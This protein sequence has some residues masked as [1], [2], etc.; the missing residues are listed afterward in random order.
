[1][2]YKNIT[3]ILFF[4]LFSALNAIAAN[5]NWMSE[6]P[7]DRILNQLIIP[8]SHDSG[9]YGIQPQS[10]FSLSP[11]DPLPIWIEAISNILPASLLTPIVAGW[12]KTQ[13]YSITEQLNNGIRY[14]DFRVCYFQSHFYLCH[15]LISVRLKN[16][17]QQIQTF[18]QKNPSE[19]IL[20][21]INHVYNVTNS[22]EETQLVQLL[23]N[24]LENTAIPNSYKITDTMKTL[25]KSHHNVIIFMNTS[26]VITDPTAQQFAAKK[27]WSESKIDSPWPDAADMNDLKNTLDTE[28][29]FRD[30]I[31]ASANNLFVLQII[32]TE[33]TDE[34]IDGILN[35]SQYPNAIEPYELPVN[36]ALGDWMNN[37]IAEYGPPPLN[38]IIQDW[39]TT[40]SP[41]VPLAIQYDTVSIPLKNKLSSGAREKLRELK[42]WCL[43][44]TAFQ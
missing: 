18:I 4:S 3:L 15:A 38:I 34:V 27:L 36:Q 33:N 40:G 10:K 24:T 39:F 21:D 20:L 35:P 17:L 16:A 32:Q 5:N 25:L 9:T 43:N 42:K 11:D 2:K 6:I 19:I 12:S 1:M 30:K 29:A 7:N 26:Q 14:L 41:L 44:N 13:P 8:G 22:A 28:M 31:Y 37:Y 23:Q